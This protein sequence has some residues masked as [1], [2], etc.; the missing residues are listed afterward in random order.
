MKK[1]TPLLFF[2]LLLSFSNISAQLKIGYV[3]SEAIMD[4][5]PDAQDAQK[6][7]DVQIDKW[8]KE[9]KE[10]HQKW[11]DKYDEYERSK[12]I[13][14]KQKKAEM[15]KQLI[16]LEQDVANY[17]Q[18]KYGANGKLFKLQ[19]ELMKPIQNQIFNA[20]DEV[21]KEEDFDFIFDRS[22][23]LIFLYAKEK[24]DVTPLVLSKLQ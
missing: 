5:L 6:S 15:E 9:I 1:L 19:E 10:L 3:D 8:D 23:D 16:A 13:M 7:I 12:L 14:S 24:Y 2:V 17:K 4:Q 18:D 21:A 20:I 11:K 22:G